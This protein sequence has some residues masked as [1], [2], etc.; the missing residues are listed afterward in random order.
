M[1]KNYYNQEVIIRY[2]LDFEFFKQIGK[3]KQ[4]LKIKDKFIS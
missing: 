1:I 3:S 4:N 2:L